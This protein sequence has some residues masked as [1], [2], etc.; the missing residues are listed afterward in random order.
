MIGGGEF[1]LNSGTWFEFLDHQAKEF[2]LLA[3]ECMVVAV[4]S[5]MAL[6]IKNMQK[7]ISAVFG[8]TVQIV[9]VW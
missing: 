8:E 7:E 1:I 4:N 5:I 9:F 2:E 6:A 3:G